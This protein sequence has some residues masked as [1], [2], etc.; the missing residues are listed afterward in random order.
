MRLEEPK[1]LVDAAR[2][3][4]EKVGS[5]GITGFVGLV[6]VVPHGV[7]EGGVAVDQRG[8]MVGDRVIIQRVGASLVSLEQAWTVPRAV[9]PSW[10]IRSAILSV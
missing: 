5:V 6:D 1:V 2:H 9:P 10:V 8:E 7:A 4:G 3:L